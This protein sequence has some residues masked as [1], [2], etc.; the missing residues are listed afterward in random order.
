VRRSPARAAALLALALAALAAGAAQDGSPAGGAQEFHGTWTVSGVRHEVPTEGR[1][2]AVA[3]SVSGAVVLAGTDALAR[4]FRGEAVAFDDGDGQSVGRCVWTD[5]HGDRV[6]SRLRGEPLEAGRR[7][8]GTITG[9]TGRYEGLE[10]EYSFSWQ[11]L[12]PTGEDVQGRAVRLSGR[13]R[14]AGA[15]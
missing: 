2:P 11:Y 12:V 1:A 6:F 13:V 7:F 5:E 15:R 14:R 9:G 3:V 10:G 8:T 4:G